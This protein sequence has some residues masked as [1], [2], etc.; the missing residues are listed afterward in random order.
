MG[1]LQQ[2]LLVL[3]TTPLYVII[4]GAEI[5]LSNIHHTHSYTRRNTF[6]NFCIS[7]LSGAV[8]VLMRG[9][10]LA[11][12]AF[13]FN[14]SFFKLTHTFFYWAA[15][16]LLVD[17]MH[18]WLHRL[19]HT[20]R[21]FWAVHV[22]HHS[23]SLYNFSVGFRAGVLEPLYRFA[24]FIPIVLL[25]FQPA[26]LLLIYSI[27]EIWAILTHTEKVR[28]M[29]WLEYILI[30]PSHHR[31]HHASNVKYLDRNMG[32]VFIFWDKLFGTFQEELSAA[33]YEPIRYGLTTPLEKETIPTIIFHEW[34]A[35]WQDLHRPGLTWKQ[36]W[37]YVF[38][39]PGW[40]HD[41]S[42]KTSEELRDMLKRNKEKTFRVPAL[43]TRRQALQVERNA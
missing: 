7:I 37:L 13:L 35:I 3:I 18:Y 6:Q 22:N 12:F 1:T 15:L 28:K 30:T 33:E 17:M 19:S 14:H 23:S 40:S 39:P 21:L 29:G 9:V 11:I 43:K 20:C 16:L 31:V 4:I 5:M 34:S 36:K 8:D 38:G 27:T 2:Q 42:R 10:S 26:D 25:G 32:S 41:G 24:F